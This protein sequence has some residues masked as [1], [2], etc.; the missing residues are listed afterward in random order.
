MTGRK[1]SASSVT[2]LPDLSFF[3]VL[4]GCRP[5][6]YLFQLHGTI[7]PGSW[8]RP[9]GKQEPFPTW[10]I[11]MSGPNNENCGEV[12]QLEQGQGQAWPQ[13]L[14]ANRETQSMAE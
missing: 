1:L 2:P 9:R 8:S 6:G 10:R 14:R 12:F 5:W 4:L 11:Y 13:V 3:C 7:L